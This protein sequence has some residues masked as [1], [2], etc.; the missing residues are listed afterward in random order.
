MAIDLGCLAFDECLALQHRVHRARKE[1]LL[2][3]C[4]LLVEHLHVLTI[5]KTGKK[6]NLLVPEPLLEER[7]IPCLAIE[8]GGDIHYHG[9]GQL[10]G[11]PIFALKRGG[12]GVIDFVERL[13]EVMIRILSDYGITGGRSETN[14]GVWVGKDK[15][16][17]VGIS[18]RRGISFHGFA[19]NVDP[20]LSFFKLIHLCG[21][22]GV[23]ATSMSTLL[24]RRIAL[25]EVKN[26]AIFY[27][28][29]VFDLSMER[30]EMDAFLSR[31]PLSDHLI[32][33]SG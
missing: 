20:D 24:G 23:K 7:G 25:E 21:L 28:E 10:T 26:R 12:I 31:V 32:C 22:K 17:F 13:E 29:E 30:M 14:R 15:V 2:P 18:V 27:F 6:E 33:L 16:G 1:S 9:P 11:Y 8:R 19:L 4:L 3:D 5:G